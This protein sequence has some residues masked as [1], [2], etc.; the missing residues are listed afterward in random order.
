MPRA[1]AAGTSGPGR[2]EHGDQ[3]DQ[4]QVAF[5]VPSVAWDRC[6]GRPNANTPSLCR[7]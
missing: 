1:I 7:A 2:A 5:R 4:A 3:S 6:A